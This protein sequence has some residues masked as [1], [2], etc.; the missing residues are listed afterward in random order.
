VSVNYPDELR[1]VARRIL[2]FGD[3]DRAL[4]ITPYFL[5]YVMNYATD[6]DLS[7]VEKFYDKSD[8][9][10][11]LE[12]AVPGIFFPDKWELW[13]RRFDRIPVPPMPTRR[14]PGVNPELIPDLFAAKDEPSEG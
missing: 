12:H 10:D 5:T 14:I 1:D 4:E 11:A 13:N 8:F 3:V 9:R 6:E 7:V 2:W